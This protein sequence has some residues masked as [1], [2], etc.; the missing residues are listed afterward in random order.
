M[1][2]YTARYGMIKPIIKTYDID[3]SKQLIS[4]ECF[5]MQE[6]VYL[7]KSKGVVATTPLFLVMLL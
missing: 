3:P 6:S 5:S 7:N 1:T 2:Y 4:I